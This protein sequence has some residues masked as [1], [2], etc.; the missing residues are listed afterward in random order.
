MEGVLSGDVSVTED[1]GRRRFL[2][3]NAGARGQWE[4]T[5]QIACRSEP[6]ARI[7]EITAYRDNA[8]GC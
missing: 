5:K 6:G 4:L 7:L 2:V 8:L 1:A 3:Y